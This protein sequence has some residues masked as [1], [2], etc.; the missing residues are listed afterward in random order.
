MAIDAW[1]V[2]LIVVAV[3]ALVVIVMAVRQRIKNLRV[4]PGSVQLENHEDPELKNHE[5]H[6]RRS[7]VKRSL[8][9]VIRKSRTSVVDTKLSRSTIR[10]RETDGPPPDRP[11]Q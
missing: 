3:V 7:K 1:Q 4:G 11:T 6:L 8:I 9:D 5:V 2:V 10:V